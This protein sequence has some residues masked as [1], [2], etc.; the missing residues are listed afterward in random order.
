MGEEDDKD[1]IESTVI[2]ADI[3]NEQ[4]R[5]EEV[6]SKSGVNADADS[7]RL[8]KYEQIA[9]DAYE[10]AKAGDAKEDKR[11]KARRTVSAITSLLGGLGNLIAANKGSLP[12]SQEGNALDRYQKAYKDLLE[13]RAKRNAVYEAEIYRSRK[14]DLKDAREARKQEERENQA[15]AKHARTMK[16]MAVEHQYKMALEAYRQTG[17]EEYL[18]KANKA[19]EKLEKMKEAGRN[20]RAREA[21][22]TR[23]LVQDSQVSTY[24]TEPVTTTTIEERN[25]A[26]TKKTNNKGEKAGFGF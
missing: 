19:K 9:T 26:S 3:Q 15:E 22:K 21:N 23:R 17:K 16:E 18:D 25:E 6:G 5:A 12:V 20:S 2:D 10:A 1:L 24:G 8:G 4:E 13:R 14:E 11:M 7:S